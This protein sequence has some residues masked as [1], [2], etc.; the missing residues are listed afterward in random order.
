MRISWLSKWAKIWFGLLSK[1]QH[2]SAVKMMPVA[3]GWVIAFSEAQQAQHKFLNYHYY[4]LYHTL[5]FLG[6]LLVR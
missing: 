6:T 5:F 1:R 3:T 2:V 4:N